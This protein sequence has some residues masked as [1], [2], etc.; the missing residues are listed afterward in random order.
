MYS[1]SNSYRLQYI[2]NFFSQQLFDH[3]IRIT[4]DKRE[5]LNY[6]GAKLNYSSLDLSDNEVSIVPVPLLFE[7]GIRPQEISCF[8]INFHKAFFETPGSLH[9]D[10]FAASFYLLSRYEEYLPHEKDEFGR[11]AHSNSLA[12]REGFLHQPLIN[13]WLQ[14]FRS[15]L[16]AKFRGLKFKGTQF[17]NVIT[18]DVD[19]AYSYLNKGFFRNIGGIFRSLWKG[20]WSAALERWQ[21]LAGKKK[22]PFDCYEWLD[23]LHL[24]CRLKP[25]FFFLVARNNS[26]YDKNV[27]TS[28][29]RFQELVE[30]YASTCNIGIH[31]SWQSGDDKTLLK[32]EVEWL[33][34]VSDT[35]VQASRQH[36]IRFTLPETYR[37]LL[38]EGI[39]KEFSMGYGSINGF[40]ASVCS[41]FKWYDLENEQATSLIVYPFCFMDANSYYEEKHTPQQ[42]YDEL[43]RMYNTVKKVNGTMI[44]IWHNHLL[45]KDRQTREWSEMFEIFMKETVYWDA[46]YDG[47]AEL[48]KDVLLSRVFS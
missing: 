25:Y 9:F 38:S 36:Y 27:S 47:S 3:P 23:A 4:T 17:A 44:T 24:Y 37:Q 40:R 15:A 26:K 43:M 46:Y 2:V 8:E 45:G 14:E 21:V 7:V 18:Y 33:E 30:Y 35:Q 48:N 34:A 42:A 5:Y 20:E 31:P 28:S 12:Y 16:T 13:V 41:S 19:I 6:P 1:L 29:K 39:R 10:I 22:D 32:E 11:Y